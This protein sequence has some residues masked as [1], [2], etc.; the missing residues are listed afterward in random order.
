MK[1]IILAIVLIVGFSSVT[2]AQ[3]EKLKEK[4]MEKVEELNAEIV[5]GDA[6][7]ALT[8]LQKEQIQQ[9]HVD[10]IKETRKLRK[11][12]AA[13]E[14]IK[15]ANKKYFKKIFTEVLTKEQKK[16]RKSGKEEEEE[17]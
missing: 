16:A 4:A 5:A 14:D 8:D 7:L 6:S 3:S 1:K 11:D 9:I 15:A 10:R 12:G 17:D 2:L 13:K